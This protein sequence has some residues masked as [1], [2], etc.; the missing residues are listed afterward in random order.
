MKESD[1]KE[2]ASGEKG[3]Y[4]LTVR[5]LR[6]DV[7]DQNIVIEDKLETQGASIVKDSIFVKKNGIELKDAKIEADDTG[8]VIQT[9]A[10]LSDKDKI[11]VCYEVV[12]K[13]KAQ[14]L[15]KICKTQRK[16]EEIF[17]R[18]LRRSRRYM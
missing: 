1:K 17:H 8:F 14:S 4:K 3:Y 12:L 5:Q 11:E 18:K 2:Y 6:E 10:S 13:Q 7:T 9:G 16:Q 15:K